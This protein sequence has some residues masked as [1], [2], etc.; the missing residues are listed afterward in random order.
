MRTAAAFAILLVGTSRLLA[1]Q[2]PDTMIWTGSEC[3]CPDGKVWG[4][5]KC[6]WKNLCPGG[7]P[8][9]NG[10]CNE[11]PTE[12]RCPSGTTLK[13]GECIEIRCR[14]GEVLV[15]GIC[16][17]SKPC[18][19][20]WTDVN[21]TCVRRIRQCERETVVFAQNSGERVLLVGGDVGDL[22]DQYSSAARRKNI[23]IDFEEL[24]V[25][26]YGPRGG[27]NILRG[28]K[29]VKVTMSDYFQGKTWQQ[30]WKEQLRGKR[31][32]VR[33]DPEGEAA[34]LKADLV[35][36]NLTGSEQ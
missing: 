31:A 15:N 17:R 13:N 19:S 28:G 26:F 7:E 25:I 23:K 35:C 2:C 14:P 27:Q 16:K 10:N 3:E 12:T 1:Q 34:V 30:V 5:S 8:S 22:F 9:L 11:E 36:G 18:P 32:V 33:S 29:D 24:A 21:G 20:G 6:E 4:G